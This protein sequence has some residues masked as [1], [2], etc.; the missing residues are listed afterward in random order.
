MIGWPF[1]KSRDTGKTNLE[2]FKNCRVMDVRLASENRSVKINIDSAEL[3]AQNW[4]IVSGWIT[5]L[6]RGEARATSNLGDIHFIL[7]DRSDV[8]REFKM[9]SNLA[10]GFTL[11]FLSPAPC[12]DLINIALTMDCLPLADIKIL[13]LPSNLPAVP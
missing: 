1:G 12:L 13:F 5:G 6:N 7:S 2:S 10:Y 11:H 8:C 4:M 3:K 9:D